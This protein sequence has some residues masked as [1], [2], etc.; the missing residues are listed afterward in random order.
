MLPPT[1]TISRRPPG[2]YKHFSVNRA[3]SNTP[4]QEEDELHIRGFNLSFLYYSVMIITY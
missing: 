4:R 1:F 3:K 2:W